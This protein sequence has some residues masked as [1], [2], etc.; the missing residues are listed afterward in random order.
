M[1]EI[2]YMEHESKNDCAW[3]L[4]FKKYDI[5]SHIEQNGFFQISAQQIKEYREPRLM[6]KFDHTIN[7]PKIF[8]Q[9]KLSILPVTRGDYVISHFEAYHRFEPLSSEII[10][11]NLPYYIQS[12]KVDA[13]T[14]EAVALN[15]AY[16]SGI[17]ADFLEDEQLV[18]TVSGR[19]GSGSFN[20]NIKD[21]LSMNQRKITVNNSQIEIDAGYEGLQKLALIEA[22]RDLSNDFLIRQLYYP[23][24]TWNT[25]VNK[26]VKPVYLV[27]S[28]GIFHLYEYKFED[29]MEYSS[30]ILVKQKNYTIEED[31]SINTEEI[32]QL[33]NDVQTNKEPEIAFPQA[34][35]FDRIVNLCELLSE[36][37]MTKDE[38]TINYAFDV[39]QTNYYTDAARYL[40]LID[41]QRSDSIVFELTSKGKKILSLRYKQRQIAFCECI[42][43]HKVFAEALRLWFRQ[44]K[45]SKM[46]IVSLMKTNNIYNI[47]K[48]STYLRRASTIKGWLEWIIRLITA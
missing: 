6:A 34:D 7:L 38:I 35:S 30:L 5:L 42:L 11:I 32:T 10:T 46:E 37:P 22:K 44:G 28:N 13:I 36:H 3:K 33:L 19:M 29:P 15:C 17:I 2:N 20:F 4:L 39:R 18:P 31:T 8:K 21:T 23:F 9:N 27:Y 12:L 48:E 1:S 24:R 16:I 43:S 41:K 45:I 25:R 47:E 40:G 26:E 14:S